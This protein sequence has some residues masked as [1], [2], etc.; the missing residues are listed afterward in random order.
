MVNENEREL[1]WDDVIEKESNFTLLPAGEYDFTVKSFERGRYE[2]GPNAKLPPCNMATVSMEVTDGELSATIEHRLFPSQP[3]RGNVVRVLPRFG[4]AQ[5]WRAAE[6]ELACCPGSART[7]Q[8]W[9]SYL[10]GQGWERH[11]E[12][13]SQEVPRARRHQLY[14]REILANSFFTGRRDE[15]HACR[16]F[17]RKGT[18]HDANQFSASRA[19][20]TSIA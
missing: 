9:R 14:T 4:P 17:L 16:C 8:D 10:E 5:A 1:G 7:L 6:N 12:Q 2:P 11:A 13:R 3:L 15:P 19:D 18:E 20:P